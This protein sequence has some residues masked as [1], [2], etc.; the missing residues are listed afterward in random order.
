MAPAEPENDAAGTSRS[1]TWRLRRIA[2]VAFDAGCWVFA[3]FAATL[4]RYE[5]DLHQVEPG[6]VALIAGFAVVGVLVVGTALQV[7]RGRHCIGTVGDAIRVSAT[8]AVLGAGLFVPNLLLA[9]PL[10]PRTA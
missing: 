3:L 1:L 2:L 5:L 7:Y 4:L 6:N 10:V 9:T 8:S